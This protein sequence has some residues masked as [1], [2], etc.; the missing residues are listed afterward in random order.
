MGKVGL[1]NKVDL[2]EG[3]LV[4]VFS[5][6]GTKIRLVSEAVKKVWKI[7]YLS[8]VFSGT[9]Q[10][11]GPELV[12][13]DVVRVIDDMA[14][15]HRLQKAGRGWDDDMVLVGPIQS[16]LLMLPSMHSL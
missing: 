16:T 10:V 14:E 9:H 2:D 8:L 11:E 3:D 5:V 7:F 15:V 4:M 1:V 13:D 12:P 6:A